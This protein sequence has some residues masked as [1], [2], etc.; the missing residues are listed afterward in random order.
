MSSIFLSYRRTDSAGWA[1]RLHD[2][3]RRLL[4][5]VPVIMD[6]ED[7]PPGVDFQDFI[8]EAVARCDLLVALMGP[9]WLEARNAKAERR[10]DDPDD[11]TRLEIEKA[12][13]R[14]IRVVPVLVGGARFPDASELPE[15]LR[16]LVRRQNFELPDR[17]WDESC[18]R[19]ARAIEQA[20]AARA[21]AGAG[22]IPADR[23]ATAPRVARSHGWMMGAAALAVVAIVVATIINGPEQ[24]AGQLEPAPS[25]VTPEPA[26]PATETNERAQ[27]NVVPARPTLLDLALE[28]VWR[29][30]EA[31][32]DPRFGLGILRDGASLRLTAI[33]PEGQRPEPLGTVTVDGD[34]IHFDTADG[35]I[36]LTATPRSSAA[37]EWDVQ[38]TATAGLCEGVQ[39][40]AQASADLHEWKGSLICPGPR[41][42]S[43]DI[44]ATLSIDR[45]AITLLLS[46]RTGPPTNL[47]LQRGP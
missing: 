15:S 12:L 11:Y 24:G 33:P 46:E 14:D 23:S 39:A 22:A 37:R 20:L 17:G 10:L 31:G 40:T 43:V 18:G 36:G 9:Q 2:S 3:L 29:V 38:W 13:K 28:G 8:E 1:G 19:L 47:L 42:E 45:Q 7:I 44:T 27:A 30:G 16:P 34:N 25:A 5:S 41:V 35:R 26:P 32:T 4:P 6:V 21:G